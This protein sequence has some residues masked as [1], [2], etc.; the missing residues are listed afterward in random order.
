MSLTLRSMTRLVKKAHHHH[1]AHGE[2]SHL[3]YEHGAPPWAG[4]V[5][6][7]L[8]ESLRV[9]GVKFTLTGETGFLER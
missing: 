1:N 6:C 7:R 5:G 3:V 2:V 9:R 4:S 8:T